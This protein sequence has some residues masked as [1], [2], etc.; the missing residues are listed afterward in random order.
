MNPHG[1]PQ[2]VTLDPA[3]DAAALRA[4]RLACATAHAA[5]PLEADWD[6]LDPLSLHLGART[7]QGQWVA[8]VRL[9]PDRRIDRLGLLPHW[10]RRGRN[11]APWPPA[12]AC[13]SPTRGEGNAQASRGFP[14]CLLPSWEKV[15]EGR[16]RGD[17]G[18]AAVLWRL[19]QRKEAHPPA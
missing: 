18:K 5:E 15:P 10:R 7:E 6:A 8:S 17:G 13:P 16:K 19:P 12:A 1:S 2:I 3:T 11:P 9:T 4:L 14:P